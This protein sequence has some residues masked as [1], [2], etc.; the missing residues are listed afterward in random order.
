MK[1]LFYSVKIFFLIFFSAFTAQHCAERVGGPRL[2]IVG[3]VCGSGR[4]LSGQYGALLLTLLV[5]WMADTL[6]AGNVLRGPADSPRMQAA[7]NAA[8]EGETVLVSPGV[9]YE[10]VQLRGRN[11]VLS[12]RFRVDQKPGLA[13]QTII[14]GSRPS[15]ADTASCLLIW[16]H[17]TAA[18][19]VEGFTFRGG[20]G[21]VWKDPAGAGTFREGGGI[22]TEFSSPI[23]R[24]N[25]IRDNVVS[26]ATSG[27]VSSGGGGIR[28]GEGSPLIENNHIV[29]NRADGYGG[30]IVL[31][32]CPNAMVRNNV[33]AFN[34]GGKDYSGGGFWATG[35]DA[36]TLNTLINNTIAYNESP[37]GSPDFG[38]RGGGV[39]VFSIRVLAYNNIIWGN[40]QVSGKP[41]NSSGATTSFQ[42]N[43]VETGY[44]G[45]GNIKT[46]PLFRDTIGFILEAG[47][48]AIDAG[49]PLA[50]DEDP[51]RNQRLATYPA[52][53]FTRC[54]MGAYGGPHAQHPAVPY[55]YAPA[56]LFSKV[57]NSPVVQTPGDSRSVNWVDVDNDNDEDLFVSN[58]PKAGENNFLY[59][60]NGTGGFTAVTD[61]P[62]VKD[63]T[64]SDGATWADYDNDGDI[65]CFVANW[66]NVNNLLYQN[67]GNGKFTQV[68]VGEIANDKGYS[69]TASWGD[70]DKDGKVDLYVANSDGTKRNFLYH[71]EGGG[72]FKRVNTGIATLDAGTSRS[73]NWTDYDDDGD[74]DLF[75]TNEND[76]KENLYRNDN[77]TAFVKITSGPLVN[78]AG[79]TMSS[80]WGDY[81]NDGDF[82]VFLAN[83]QGNDALFQNQNSGQSFLK[84]TNTPLGQSGG[85]SFGSQWADV[86]NDGDLD[87]FVT[88][89]FWGGPWQNFLY[90]NQ[91]DG[92]F[93][94]DTAEWPS[95]DLGWSYGC[96]FGDFDRDGDLDL[97]VANC[98]EAKQTE[99]LYENHAAEW[100]R[101]WLGV[102]CVGT[103]SNKS[104]IGAKVIVEAVVNGKALRQTREISAQSGYCGQNQLAAHIGLADATLA[105]LT[106]KWPSGQV[107]EFKQVLV[108]QYVTITEDQ[109]ITDVETPNKTSEG[110]V[111]E[112]PSPNPFRD[113]VNIRWEQR[114]TERVTVEIVDAKG[115]LVL[116][117]QLATLPAGQHQWEWD[118]QN[119]GQTPAP[120]GVYLLTIKGQFFEESRQLVKF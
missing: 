93:V 58:G 42:Y 26:P 96:A 99:Y 15:H 109:G 73:V 110:A 29:H 70:Y 20:K 63:G 22:L 72:A 10:D 78:D 5:L 34:Y 80:S 39:W 84:I 61:D 53:G 92:S 118:G 68:T 9:Y 62:I 23:L 44:F 85:N 90:F 27:M 57:L 43:C 50:T 1:I 48:P 77:G 11:I 91:G 21:T 106:V 113:S 14:D 47:S 112:A 98:Y 81:D 36:N 17:E 46:D 52:R 18:T 116:R 25:I 2:R 115:Q 94:R 33:I 117:Q 104:A 12:S 67:N 32:F 13:A 74:V 55:L 59:L 100:N 60:N 30:G 31:N 119:S 45:T 7:V 97:G 35:Q 108:D 66:W 114:K 120:A 83:D 38:G 95:K 69:E 102:R 54:D 64:P 4:F 111:L 79:K 49:R 6:H 105:D 101:H 3:S 89:A 87:L 40:K 82:D 37:A 107:Q 86:D 56:S 71:N 16:K 88:N 41:I 8:E 24:H 75:V 51:S 76:E 65:D 19:V 103:V 28:C